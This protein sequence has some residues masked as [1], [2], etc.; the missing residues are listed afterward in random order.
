MEK[1]QIQQL[2]NNFLINY[3]AEAKDVIWQEQSAK[4]RN[5]W[6][7]KILKDPNEEL[8]DVDIDDIIRILDRNGRGNTRESEAIAQ[9][10]IAQGAYRRMF[11]EMHQNK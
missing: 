5:F 7:G 6:Q 9:A 2:F 3:D 1:Q 4:F 11:N 8:N 10:M